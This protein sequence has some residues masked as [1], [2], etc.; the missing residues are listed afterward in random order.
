MPLSLTFLTDNLDMKYKTWGSIVLLLA[1]LC[2]C[3]SRVELD[4]VA[5][6][7]DVE[8]NFSGSFG[9]FKANG[10]RA[11]PTDLAQQRLH[12]INFKGLRVVFYSVS[13]IE[14]SQPDKVVYAFD[15]DVV[16]DKGKFSGKDFGRIIGASDTGCSFKLNGTHKIS[17]GDY[18]IYFFGT[19]NNAL[20]EAT[21]VGKPFS[22]IQADMSYSLTEDFDR[23]M[24]KNNHYVSEPI[25]IKKSEFESQGYG[26][27][28]ALKPASM[29]AIN[30][31]V[32]VKYAPVVNDPKLSIL[33]DKIIIAADVQNKGYRLFPEMDHHLETT[34]HLKYPVDNNY[35]GIS[36]KSV[37]ELSN[38]FLY[39]SSL[40]G[41]LAFIASANKEV[42]RYLSIPENTMAGTETE[43][44]VVTRLLIGVRMIPKSLKDVLR[45]DQLADATLSWLR[46]GGKIYEAK[47]FLKRYLEAK[48][49]SNPSQEEQN[50]I[51]AGSNIITGKELNTTGYEDELIQYYRKS[52]C[53][54]TIPIT[55]F[56]R[57]KL[58]GN[59]KQGGYYGVVRNH[60]Y[61][62]VIKSFSGI[63]KAN[64]SSFSS[65]YNYLTDTFIDYNTD[66][67]DMDV[68]TKVIETLY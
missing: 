29:S 8:V 61:E 23:N 49:K 19:P 18:I 9:D 67:K 60:H 16:A 58:G 17:A 40:P 22:A 62:Y 66:I 65:N 43:A 5:H 31:M 44:N 36:S 28:F 12:R 13:T 45:E 47:S 32:S 53:Y 33:D 24:M 63:G 11:Y 42:N 3:N 48:G 26:N 30:G 64:Y 57:E 68:V 25:R 38:E 20:R 21:A 4:R 55:H 6:A 46:Y 52:Y 14:S 37:S 10:P 35:S 2:S 56:T 34:L 7:N 1:L 15:K 39:N 54:F 27:V 51:T 41:F 59:L 50:L